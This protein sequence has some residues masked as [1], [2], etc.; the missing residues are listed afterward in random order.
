MIKTVLFDLG[1]VILPFDLTRLAGRLKPYSK[2]SIDE[3]IGLLWSDEVANSFETGLMA[4][5][6]YFAH[7]VK[8][9]EF[10]GLTYEKFVPIF[11]EIFVEDRAVVDLIARLRKKYRLGLISNTNAIHVG[12]VLQTYDSLKNF[13]RL[14]F[15]NIE[16]VRKP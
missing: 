14:W 3:I 7:A 13:E 15:S 8:E 9:C 16:R 5:Q 4:P 2:K 12:Y 6:E 1:N 10:E 11:N